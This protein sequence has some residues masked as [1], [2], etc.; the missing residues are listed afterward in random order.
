MLERDWLVFSI[1]NRSRYTVFK[2]MIS[3]TF[4]QNK[5]RDD[6][7]NG[8]IYI[9]AFW[10]DYLSTVLPK[11]LY[12]KGVQA[13]GYNYRIT[14][15]TICKDNLFRDLASRFG[16]NTKSARNPLYFMY[17]LVQ[18][19][20]WLI[21][22]RGKGKL[23]SIEIDGIKVGGYLADH[24]IRN[25]KNIY[26]VDQLTVKNIKHILAFSWQIKSIL[27]L[28]KK[29]PPDIY[30]IQEYDYWYGP[31]AKMADLYG[32]TVINCDSHNRCCFLG[33]KYGVEMCATR[34]FSFQI[35]QYLENHKGEDYVKLADEYF[36]KRRKGLTDEAAQD[37]YANKRLLTRDEW[38]NEVGADIS[39]KNIVIMA[40]CFSD[41]ASSSTDRA[42]YKNYYEWLIRT[43]D[44]IHE[45]SNVNWLLKAHPSRDFYNE[46]DGIYA[47]FERYC[48]KNNIFVL[49][50][51]ISNNALF[52]IVDGAVT[53][54]GTCGLEFSMLGIPVVCAGF[55]SYGGYGFTKEPLTENEYVEILSRMDKISKLDD[56]QIE[57][58]KKISYAYFNMHNSID[59]DEEAMN[60]AYANSN[61]AEANDNL[62]EYFVNKMENDYK[63]EDTWHYKKGK[64]YDEEKTKYLK[65]YD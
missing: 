55:A 15:L 53:V 48:D 3:K 60:A 6:L 43:L 13:C 8:N 37:A 36:E 33:G 54:L 57:T 46:G 1:K 49:S 20:Y 24:I 11:M 65:Y 42:I 62:I 18:S 31:V 45:I 14:A 29:N 51:E 38:C 16:I 52:N 25:K 61:C 7:C 10:P 56:S 12:A 64:L 39:K 28:F 59:E 26:N 4:L 5:N 2:E 17:A 9:D 22:Y 50:D 63:L 41:A 34:Q 19:V 27:S 47:I 40:H 23:Y 35:K 21:F 30:L 32:A 44:I 58:A